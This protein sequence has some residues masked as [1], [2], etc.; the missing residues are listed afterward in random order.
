MTFNVAIVGPGRSKQGTGPYIARTFKQLGCHVQ[1]VVSSSLNSATQAAEQLKNDYAIECR[2]YSSLEELLSHNA[3][4]IVAICSPANSHYQ[5]L[6]TALQANCHVF[7]EKPLWWQYNKKLSPDD[8]QTITRQATELINLCHANKKIL[9]L[10]TQ[11]PYTLSSYYE[12]YPQIKNRQAIDSFAMWLAPQSTGSAMVVDTASHVLSMLY[13]LVG[14]GKINHVEISYTGSNNQD[15]QLEFDYLHAYGDTRTTVL[16]AS[17]DTFPKSAAYAINGY[18]VDRHVE[19]PDY[20]ISL[21]SESSQI[22]LED[23]LVCSVKNFIST[24]HSKAA[25]DEVAIIDGMT[26]LAQL[27]Q[28][29]TQHNS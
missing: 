3:I 25:T 2:A 16:L 27:Y 19:L 23:P 13:T 6:N 9:Q 20:L 17:S 4:D 12:L 8:T 29:V 14:A 28:A 10:N 26:Q 11:W 21:R 1:A 7:C 5:H 15:M 24:I 18:R 22:P